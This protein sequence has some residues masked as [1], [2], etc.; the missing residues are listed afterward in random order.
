[1]MNSCEKIR[2]SPQECETIAGKII[3]NLHGRKM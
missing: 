2:K 1:M 3:E